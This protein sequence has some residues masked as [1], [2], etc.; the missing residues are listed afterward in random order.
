M[1]TYPKR[2]SEKVLFRETFINDTYVK[3]NGGT[4]TG[5]PTIDNGVTTDGSVDDVNY[6]DVANLGAGSWSFSMKVSIPVA[7][8]QAYFFS[9][10]QDANNRWY[11]RANATGAI[12]MYCLV[13]GNIRVSAT[14]VDPI[15]TSANTDYSIQVV[16]D[17][18]DTLRVYA[19][20]SE[21][22][23]NVT[24]FT[25]DNLDNT[26]DFI[27]G[28]WNGNYGAFTM[29]DLTIYSRAL[30][31]EEVL[32]IYQRDTFTEIDA[33]KF[34][35]FLPML[36]KFNDGSN[37]VTPN[38]GE[39]PN[40]IM[41][42]GAGSDEPALLTPRRGMNWSGTE[43]INFGNTVD[44]DN[45]EP[46]SFTGMFRC[47]GTAVDVIASKSEGAGGGYKGWQVYIGSGGRLSFRIYEAGL[48]SGIQVYTDNLFN[49]A[50]P[51]TFSV[52][53]DGSQV[54]DGV[55]MYVDGVEETTTTSVDAGFVG[56]TLNSENLLIGESS[57]GSNNFSGDI[58]FYGQTD[59]VL[60]PNQVREL[61][62]QFYNN[63]NI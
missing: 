50:R 59:V 55:T 19:N 17:R 47:E 48:A 4:T 22:S 44:F 13:G 7:G 27:V 10:F 35:I 51:H 32:D 42:D 34:G 3:D 56:S 57:Y 23:A 54:A 40:G 12:F 31:D 2:Q 41:G 8:V 36:T 52:T 62:N 45:D 46:V 1:L 9:K 21:V 6:G 18:D 61:S 29:K 30:S 16:G 5:S 38:I 26:G 28:Q 11:V 14:T 15:I 33:S 43:Y 63:L 37:I 53:Y 24:T 20:G 39:G 58:I 25:A 60:T 49:D